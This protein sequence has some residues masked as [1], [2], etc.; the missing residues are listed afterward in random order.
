MSPHRLLFR[1]GLVLAK[2]VR[3]GLLALLAVWALSVD[4]PAQAQLTEIIPSL[5]TLEERV[6]GLDTQVGQLIQQVQ[7]GA[8]LGA[9]AGLQGQQLGSNMA[10]L[11]DEVRRLTGQVEDLQFALED[12]RALQSAMLTFEQR[13]AAVEQ[14]SQQQAQ[15]LAQ[16]QQA[17]GA[18]SEQ[19]AVFDPAATAALTAPVAT[20][21]TL[22]GGGNQPLVPQPTVPVL[23]RG[24]G[25]DSVSPAG[26]A[27]IA[28]TPKQGQA[29]GGDALS[30]LI[31][32]Q[33]GG[34][35]QQTLASASDADRLYQM[36]IDTIKQGQ[37]AATLVAAV[38]RQL[39]RP[40]FA[41]K[42]P[43]LDGR[44]LLCPAGLQQRCGLFYPR[45]SPRFP[46]AESARYAAETWVFSVCAEQAC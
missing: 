31:D 26:L 30:G 2:G 42:R 44:N 35:S 1:P 25:P 45:L 36:A 15:A 18:S 46:R 9:A 12:L 19:G 7:S 20:Q 11:A 40:S 22:Q 21:T 23:D 43:V 4:A 29:A 32:Q 27:A 41:A 10:D 39:R 37:F 16:V 6:L 5:R 17:A 8:G 28:A 14:R 13:L 3:A 33:V 24:Q 38:H 34:A